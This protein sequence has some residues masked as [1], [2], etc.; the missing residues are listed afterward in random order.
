MGLKEYIVERSK[1]K[2]EFY[3]NN[4]TPLFVKDPPRSPE[5]EISEFIDSLES[6]IPP[7]YFNSV[8]VIY[9]GR[10]PE[11]KD[12]NAIFS[13][14]AIYVTNE[15]ETVFDMVENVIHEIAHALELQYNELLYSDGNMEKEFLGK[16]R[17]LKSLLD[18]EGYEIPEKYYLEPDYNESFDRFLSEVVGYPILLNLT[19]G[20][21]VSP[22]GATS[23]REY[24]AN[25]F[26]NYYLENPED[27][28]KISPV[29]YNKIMSIDDNAATRKTDD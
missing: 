1:D 20:L 11:L 6:M 15:E 22:Y 7:Y 3:I 5:V 25:G 17:R 21:F 28:R 8:D 18:A 13:D 2:K 27:V 14:G 4:R 16:R 10:F 12:K 24:F 19:M 29:V 9:I 26:E 23:L